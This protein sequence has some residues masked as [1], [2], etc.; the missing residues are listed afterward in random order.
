MVKKYKINNYM[1]FLLI[2]HLLIIV[3]I[4]TSIQKSALEHGDKVIAI[5]IWALITFY[6]INN[7]E[8]TEEVV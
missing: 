3:F 1:L 5:S 8:I 4:I 2:I 6:A 7:T